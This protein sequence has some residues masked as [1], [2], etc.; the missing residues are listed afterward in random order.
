MTALFPLST[1]LA[2]NELQEKH[3]STW[4]VKSGLVVGQFSDGVILYK[5]HRRYLQVL[6]VNGDYLKEDGPGGAKERRRIYRQR[7][8]FDNG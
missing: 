6:D 1:P 8:G 5:D 3:L 4:G 2:P 7:E